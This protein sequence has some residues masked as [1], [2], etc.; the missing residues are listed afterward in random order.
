MRARAKAVHLPLMVTN[1]SF[2]T[3]FLQGVLL[4]TPIL[5]VI[6]AGI[7]ITFSRW[8]DAPSAALYSL[9]GFGI[10]FVLCFAIPAGQPMVRQYVQASSG[11]RAQISQLLVLLGMLWGVLRAVS[12]GFILAAIFAGRPRKSAL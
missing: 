3:E 11:D 6:L 9:I 7:V 1:Y 5:L 8:N 2:V 10:A 12:Y 4:Q